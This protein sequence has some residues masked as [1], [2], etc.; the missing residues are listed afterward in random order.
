MKPSA[1]KP[2]E[3]C[4]ESD[5]VVR[6]DFY[7]AA[8]QPARGILIICHGYKGFKDWGM[9]PHVAQSLAE[10]V[11]VISI[12]FS[13]N[14]VGSDLLE[15]T[16]LE[17][18]A[19]ETYS[20]DLEDLHAVVNDI[21]NREGSATQKPILL[22][23]H[24]RG[25]SVC[26]IYAL[27]HPEHIAGVISWNGIANVDLFTEENKDEMRATGRTYTMNGRTKQ[28]MPLDLEILEDM[29]HNRERFD[30]VGRISGAKFPIALIQGA[31]DGERGLRGSK[32]LVEQNAA[33]TWIKIPE[34]NHT[35]GSVHPYQGETK[36][37]KDAIRET[38]RTIKGMLA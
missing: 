20:K 19:R 26:M 5:R 31:E 22:L 4:I 8:S 29:E 18:F 36:P 1:G 25:A 2:F 13:H 21:R 35:F 28:N 37:L 11:D 15:F 30:I 32:R 9:F 7:E 6:G 27:D 14:G 17:K 24:S 23:G 10:D 38:K 16:E 33:I 34:G 3:R 12:N